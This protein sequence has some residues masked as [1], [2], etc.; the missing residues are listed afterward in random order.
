M[1]GICLRIYSILFS[2]LDLKE[3]L[4]TLKVEEPF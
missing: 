3:I 1:E 4:F 2:N